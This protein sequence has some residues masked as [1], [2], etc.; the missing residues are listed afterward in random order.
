MIGTS[1]KSGYVRA[2]MWQRGMTVD[3]YSR[4]A[5]SSSPNPRGY[6][7]AYGCLK[8][9]LAI[10]GRSSRRGLVGDKLY[11]DSLMRGA[12]FPVPQALGVVGRDGGTIARLTDGPALGRLLRQG[13]APL[14][15]KPTQAVG[16]S[17]PIAVFGYNA[18]DNLALTSAGD[19]PPWKLFRLVSD[20]MPLGAL[21]QQ[22]LEQHE[23]LNAAVG[24]HLASL[25]LTTL[26]G[27]AG[28]EIVHGFWKA[29]TGGAVADHMWRGNLMCGL[30]LNSGTV[31]RVLNRLDVNAAN[32]SKHPD[33]G[34][35]LLGLTL[36]DF[37]KARALVLRA[38]SFLSEL[39][40]AGWDVGIT[41]QGPV[42][43]EANSN[44]SLDVPQYLQGEAILDNP[45][46]AEA[47]SSLRAQ[48]KAARSARRKRKWA[49]F[50]LHRRR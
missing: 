7:G 27:A 6:L 46:F 14:F 43:I 22:K 20:T 5:L 19:M 11:F 2:R 24:P 4:L 8:F 44:P 41:A 16:E 42:I 36:P 23:V 26:V 30:D 38:A 9:A 3:E 15:I 17:D 48:A 47:W 49:A 50:R 34:A 31:T 32:I 21:V 12:G 28:P 45:A 40:L 33:T 37:A 18:E 25:R 35:D 29:P 13:Q 1:P 39:P 10:T